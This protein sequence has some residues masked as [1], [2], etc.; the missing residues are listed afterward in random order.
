MRVSPARPLPPPSVNMSSILYGDI[1]MDLGPNRHPQ[2]PTIYKT[3]SHP[4]WPS[5]KGNIYYF[6]QDLSMSAM[7]RTLELE[8]HLRIPQVTER[9]E[10][11]ALDKG[12]YRQHG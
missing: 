1:A 11:Q 3:T 2:L 6:L 7:M 4:L 12:E 5:Q 8:K 10:S 9:P